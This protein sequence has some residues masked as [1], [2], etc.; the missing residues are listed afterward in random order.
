V[1]QSGGEAMMLSDGWFGGYW[2]DYHQRRNA[3]T[4]PI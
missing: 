2:G 3:N 4:R 1:L